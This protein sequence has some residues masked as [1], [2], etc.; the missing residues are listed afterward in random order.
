MRLKLEAGIYLV[1]TL[2]IYFSSNVL[3]ALYA[4]SLI[5]HKANAPTN[6]ACLTQNTPTDREIETDR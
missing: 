6:A 1:S 5:C 3:P 4:Q 2:S